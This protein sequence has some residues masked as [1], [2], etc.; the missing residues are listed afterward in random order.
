MTEF[1]LIAR[2]FDRPTHR[3]RLGVGDDCALLAPRAGHE[4]AVSTDMLVAGRHFLADADPAGL[5]WKSLAVNLSD[6]AAMGAEPVA[7]TLALALPAIDEAWLTAFASG[8]FECAERFDCEL[9]GGDTTRGPLNICITVFGDVPAGGA[10]RRDGARVDDDVWVSG[11]VGDAALALARTRSAHGAGTSDLAI[12]DGPR[13]A[14]ERPVPRIALGLALVGLAT[15]AIDVSDGLAQ[16][17]GHVLAASKVGAMVIVDRL[18]VS[19]ALAREGD[20]VRYHCALAGGDDYQLCFTAPP[21]RRDAVEAAARTS[22][23]RVTRIGAIESGGALRF[24]DHHGADFRFPD[25]MSLRGFD[26]F[27]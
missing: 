12:A 22:G 15:S 21:S 1:E 27:A 26:H 20:D 17:L 16:D 5:G 23:T 25:G 9:V 19:D 10:L 18:P 8:L 13:A 2:Y 11:E 7:F 24:V 6:L 3:A 4:L 14:L